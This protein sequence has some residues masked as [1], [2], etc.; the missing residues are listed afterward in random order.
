MKA[1]PITT[2]RTYVGQGVAQAI[3]TQLCNASIWFEVTPL[4]DD[5]WGFRVKKEAEHL[6]PDS[7]RAALITRAEAMLSKVRGKVGADQFSQTTIATARAVYENVL[8][9]SVLGFDADYALSSVERY[10]ENSTFVDPK[11]D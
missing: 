5:C 3:S 2:T 4:P 10:I 6:L 9:G 1:K 8:V 11:V 7:D